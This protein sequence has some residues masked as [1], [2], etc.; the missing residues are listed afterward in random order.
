MKI[1]NASRIVVL[2]DHDEV[3]LVRYDDS[4]AADP[5]IGVKTYWVPPGGGVHEGETDEQAALRELREETTLELQAARLVWLRERELLRK[6]ELT[7]YREKYFFARV[8]GRP[9]LSS[10]KSSEG[11]TDCRW[12]VAEDLRNRGDVIFPSNFL[13]LLA[14]L[15]S[16]DI[17]VTPILVE[18]VNS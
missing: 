15:T 5:R 7:L 12:R 4:E 11:I 3:L 13:V 16:G 8:P 18:G 2:N 14:Q 9:K 10:E 6:G 17:P 1:R